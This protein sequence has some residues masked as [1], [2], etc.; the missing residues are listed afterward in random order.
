[1]NSDRMRSLRKPPVTTFVEDETDTT[2]LLGLAGSPSLSPLKASGTSD[3]LMLETE[4]ASTW[5]DEEDQ[6]SRE[7]LQMIKART[8]YEMVEEIEMPG[9]PC[10]LLF[11][12]NVQADLLASSDD[13]L[14]KML[15]ALELPRP[16]LV[17]NLLASQGFETYVNVLGVGGF[18]SDAASGSAGIVS[19]RTPFLTPE[20]ERAAE[21]RVDGFMADVLIPLAAQTNAIVIT[22]PFPDSILTRSLMR[23]YA[24]QRSK[25]GGKPPFTIIAM[26]AAIQALYCNGNLN[27]CWRDARRQSRAWRTRDR[28]LLELVHRTMAKPDGSLPEDHSDFD[29][30]CTTI[31]T[32]DMIESKKESKWDKGPFTSLLNNIV[33]Y[34]GSTLPSLTIKTSQ[35]DMLTLAEAG[36]SMSCIDVALNAA[37]GGSPVLFLDVRERPLAEASDRVALIEAAK[38]AFEE[39]CGALLEAGLAESFA[40]CSI[41]YFYDVLHGKLDRKSVV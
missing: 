5:A 9:G 32:T 28:K 13:S 2:P 14:Q 4:V 19:N 15:D 34:L 24:V 3:A 37:L 7:K 31:I 16:Q 12:T 1:M 20:E 30:N 39:H 21:Q 38:A 8:M 27:A 23:M 10:K 40:C 18:D 36:K 35:A 25:W 6:L 41:A 29:P 11:L 22:S 33:R 17:I 26:G